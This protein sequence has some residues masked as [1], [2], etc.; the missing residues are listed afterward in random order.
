MGTRRGRPRGTNVRLHPT[1]H[2]SG[3]PTH[4]GFPL[5][6]YTAK[7]HSTAHALIA[8]VRD[9]STLAFYLL[10]LYGINAPLLA[11]DLQQLISR[12]ETTLNPLHTDTVTLCAT[13]RSA[14]VGVCFRGGRGV[15]WG[16]RESLQNSR[17]LLY[18]V[19]TDLTP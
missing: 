8:I 18:F 9:T 15:V 10:E 17:I 4:I 11:L 5:F 19:R 16:C 3:N 12:E 14:V 13:A 2:S 1:N 7:S 6:L